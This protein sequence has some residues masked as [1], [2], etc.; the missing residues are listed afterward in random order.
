MI[1]L[2]CIDAGTIQMLEMCSGL[3]AMYNMQSISFYLT[4]N[5]V[6]KEADDHRAC[7][8]IFFFFF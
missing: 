3:F 2:L 6:S 7:Q 5:D 1:F 8:N 4:W